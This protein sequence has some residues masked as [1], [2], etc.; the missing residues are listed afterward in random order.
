MNH[1]PDGYQDL[2]VGIYQCG[3][4]A[5]VASSAWC[6]EHFVVNSSYQGTVGHQSQSVE[7]TVV[8][9]GRY[10]KS[11]VCYSEQ[12][13]PGANILLVVCQARFDI[14]NGLLFEDRLVVAKG[15]QE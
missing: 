6:R 7:T 12:D 4:L 8:D 5:V 1:L 14:S 13:Q 9:G 2:Y 3:D 11:R 15:C 10:R